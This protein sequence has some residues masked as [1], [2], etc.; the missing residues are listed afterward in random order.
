MATEIIYGEHNGGSYVFQD[1]KSAE[2]RTH[3]DPQLK[4]TG[5]AEA[6]VQLGV[7]PAK[8]DEDDRQVDPGVWDPDDGQFVTLSRDG[9]NRAIR[10]LRKFRDQ[11]YG[12]DE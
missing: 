12:K 4:I 9:I 10:A 5:F 3:W 6:G 2:R 1:G 8:V 7:I 11:A